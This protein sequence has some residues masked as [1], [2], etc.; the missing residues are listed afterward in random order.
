MLE[1]REGLQ[2]HFIL[3]EATSVLQNQKLTL[4]VMINFGRFR[5]KD[6]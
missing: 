3:E 2:T 1:T 5:E 4:Y 6:L